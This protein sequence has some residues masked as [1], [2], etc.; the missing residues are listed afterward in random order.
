MPGARRVAGIL[1]YNGVHGVLELRIPYDRT[2]ASQSL[3]KG[4]YGHSWK[5]NKKCWEYPATVDAARAV[6]EAFDPDAGAGFADWYHDAVREARAAQ[7]ALALLEG[8]A[9]VTGDFGF[10]FTTE[11]YENQQQYCEWA[12][13]RSLAGLTYR[14]NFSQQGTGKTKSEIDMTVWELKRKLCT[15]IPLVLCPNS[16]KTEWCREILK[17]GPRELFAPVPLNGSC[18]EKLAALE[19]TKH[20]INKVGLCPVVIT[21]YDVLSQPSQKDVLERLL[22]WAKDGFFGKVIFDEASMIRN[23]QSKRGANAFKFSKYIPIR[24]SMTGTPYPKRPTDVFNPLRVLSTAILGTSWTAFRKHHEVM[25][26]WQNKEV[27]DY[28]NLDGLKKKV[29]PHVFRKLLD[30]CTDLPEEIHVTR[31]CDMSKQQ[32]EAT[33]DLRKQMMAEL[34][35]EDGSPMV[36]SATEVMVRLL[37]FNQITS[38]WLRDRKNNKLAFFKPNPKLELLM[39]YLTDELPEDEKAVVWTCYQ[40]DVER[41]AR[42]CNERSFMAVKYYG[43]NKKDREYQEKLFLESPAYRV[44]VATTDAGGWGLNWQIACHSIDYSY[45]FNWETRDQARARIRRI[46]QRKRMTYVSL[47]AEHPTT[48]QRTHGVSTGINKYIL[49]NLEK[50]TQ[51]AGELTGDSEKI[52]ARRMLRL[53]LE[54]V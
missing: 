4:I 36:L 14:A 52:D 7:R 47:V 33:R 37:R 23:T 16:V 43:G 44:M 41:I 54:A 10:E 9:E 27:V 19:H 18:E 42:A 53:G 46:T 38:G 34:E 1:S 6:I 12:A 39:G 17:H 26:G 5:S 48:R 13:T 11:P 30:E 40:D 21:N 15:G 29:D 24:V 35:T 45:N 28:K 32:I 50:T 20:L 22:T 3:A 8:K 2:G 31:T 49:D 51:M 25:G